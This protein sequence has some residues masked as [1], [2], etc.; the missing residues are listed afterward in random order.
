MTGEI[1]SEKITPLDFMSQGGSVNPEEL[2]KLTEEEVQQEVIEDEQVPAIKERDSGVESEPIDSS[3]EEEEVEQTEYDVRFKGNLTKFAAE[4]MKKKGLLPETYEIK[5]EITEEEL[6]EALVQYREEPLRNQVRKEELKRL[7]E[8]GFTDQMIEE[9]KY[10]YLGVQ[11]DELA[12]MQTLQVLSSYK[13]DTSSE[14]FDNDAK[15]FLTSYY[16]M[17][18]VPR[19][20]IQG[21]VEKD[22][23]D[24]GIGNIIKE[25]QKELGTTYKK[26]VQG[27]QK[28]YQDKVKERRAAAKEAREREN[29]LIQSGKIRELTL[30]ETD[31]DYVYK[32]LNEKT[33]IVKGEDGNYYRTTLYN[34]KLIEAS[35]DEEL[36]LLHKALV[37]LGL[38]LGKFRNQEREKVSKQINSR[39]NKY[40]EIDIKNNQGSKNV[41]E[42]GIESEPL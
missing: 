26:K 42:R 2:E 21:I 28:Q 13:F 41:E 32:A 17:S 25:Y 34:K 22:L 35:R 5:E 36:R 10:K 12:E 3:E 19:R 29:K 30:S 7:K 11:D 1:E 6:D 31:R 16:L 20:S 39:L 37:V 24:P 9:V 23:D 4:A 33:E 38:D 18:N 15:E 14:T 27:Y 40:V 8:E